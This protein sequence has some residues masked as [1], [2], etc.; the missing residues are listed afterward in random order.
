M[1]TSGTLKASEKSTMEQLVERAC[2]RDYQ[3]LGLGTISSNSSR[4]KTEYLRVTA[5]NRMYSLCR[6]W[7]C[8][9]SE[10]VENKDDTINTSYDVSIKATYCEKIFVHSRSVQPVTLKLFVFHSE[11]CLLVAVYVFIRFGKTASHGSQKW[12]VRTTPEA[13]SDNTSLPSLLLSIAH[14]KRVPLG[15]LE[16]PNLHTLNCLLKVFL[17]LGFLYWCLNH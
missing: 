13:V 10:V 11:I 5:L 6:R 4:S 14:G 2:F 12:A 1:H 17:S 3:R 9:S 7:V 15:L 8:Q 16:E